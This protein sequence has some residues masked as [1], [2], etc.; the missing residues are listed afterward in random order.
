MT[1]KI[2]ILTYCAKK[3]ENIMYEKNVKNTNNFISFG[4]F[5][6]LFLGITTIIFKHSNITFRRFGL[7]ILCLK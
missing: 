2:G 5:I 7:T 6:I 4:Q 1:Y 3:L